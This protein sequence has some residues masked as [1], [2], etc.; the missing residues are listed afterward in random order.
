[1]PIKELESSKN[2]N[3]CGLLQELIQKLSVS[4]LGLNNRPIS[5]SVFPPPIAPDILLVAF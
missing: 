4:L 5:M 3:L 1:M 2:D